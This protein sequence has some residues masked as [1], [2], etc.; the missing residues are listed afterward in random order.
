M[1][2]FVKIEFFIATH[3]SLHCGESGDIDFLSVVAIA[4]KLLRINGN[5]VSDLETYLEQDPQKRQSLSLY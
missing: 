1:E 3:C 4:M 2:N 5:Q